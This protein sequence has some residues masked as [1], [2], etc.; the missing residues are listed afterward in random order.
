MILIRVEFSNEFSVRLSEVELSSS[1]DLAA[2]RSQGFIISCEVSSSSE[3]CANEAA[4]PTKISLSS[5]GSA[6]HFGYD[7]KAPHSGLAS[8][9][10][11]EI[12]MKVIVLVLALLSVALPVRAGECFYLVEAKVINERTRVTTT[13][14]S[15]IV[16]LRYPPGSTRCDFDARGTSLR[17][18]DKLREQFYGFVKAKNPEL[19]L[20]GRNVRVRRFDDE[21][22]VKALYKLLS[23]LGGKVDDTRFLILIS[24]TF[25]TE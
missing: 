25:Y 22:E 6:L 19:A 15:D 9:T 24:G 8:L 18:E 2:L 20:D 13:F 14:L 4:R 5:D 17:R 23:G 11:R 16:E 7:S 10:A 3:V 1:Q 12:G 21:A